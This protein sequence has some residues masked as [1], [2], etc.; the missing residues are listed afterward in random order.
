MLNNFEKARKSKRI[1][2]VDIAE[3]IGVKYQTVSEK[4]NGKSSFKLDEVL[5]ISKTYFPEYKIEYLFKDDE[6]EEL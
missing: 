3:L 6:Q 5:L 4:I 1:R 2:L